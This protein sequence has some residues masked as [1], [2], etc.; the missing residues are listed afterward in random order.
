MPTTMANGQLALTLLPELGGCIA[1]L[2]AYSDGQWID[3]LRPTPS[4]TTNPGQTSSFLMLPWANRI[5]HGRFTFD[6]QTYQLRTTPDDGTARHGDVRGRPWQVARAD[7]FVHSLTFD[8]R[9]HEGVNWP[10]TFSAQQTFTLNDNQINVHTTLTNLDARPM[11]GGFGHHPYFVR[12][13]DPAALSLKISASGYFPLTEALLPIGEVRPVPPELDF[14]QSRPILGDH[15]DHLLTQL[16]HTQP[17]EIAY[18]RSGLR[19]L[20]TMEPAYRHIL[21]YTPP[22]EPSIA[23]E[24]MTMAT[25]AHNLTLDAAVTG[26]W[27]IP[28]GESRQAA[29]TLTVERL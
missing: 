9:Q 19:V 22:G 20:L 26:L 11:P 8:S 1:R 23:I 14:R 15:Y 16:D 21:I 29:F 6:G 5:A 17:I 4:D 27:V 2:Q 3:L 28:P 18:H 10:F 24:P 7:A 13:A 25:N 12:P